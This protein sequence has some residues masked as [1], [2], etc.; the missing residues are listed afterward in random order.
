M[1]KSNFQRRTAFL[2][3]RPC[4]K[5]SMPRSN[6]ARLRIGVA[7]TGGNSPGI[8]RCSQ[9]ESDD[10]G[11]TDPSVRRG[12][13]IRG[14]RDSLRDFGEPSAGLRTEILAGEAPARGARNPKTAIFD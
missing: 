2:L 11:E 14:C 1:L 7:E 5:V 4:G 6:S 12:Y 13:P 9:R 8:R 10:I 3:A